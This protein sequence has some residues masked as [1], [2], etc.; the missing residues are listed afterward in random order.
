MREGE[1]E[2]MS[3]RGREGERE[4]ININKHIQQ[5][6]STGTTVLTANSREDTC[7]YILIM[8]QDPNKPRS[9]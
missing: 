1:R 4:R 2:I 8:H 7:A 9:L 5:L 3:E 6:S